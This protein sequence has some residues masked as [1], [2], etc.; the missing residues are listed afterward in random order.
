[1]SPV[2]RYISNII[3]APACAA[4]SVSGNYTIITGNVL[5]DGGSCFVA[6]TKYAQYTAGYSGGASWGGNYYTE[7]GLGA[8]SGPETIEP[9]ILGVAA[10]KNT[11]THIVIQPISV[12]A[13]E[14]VKQVWIY[15]NAELL[16]K[17]PVSN[18]TNFTTTFNM[19]PTVGVTLITARVLDLDNNLSDYSQ[20]VTYNLI[21]KV[22]PPLTAG[23][24]SINITANVT[25]PVGAIDYD[26]DV[27]ASINITVAS[28]N[29]AIPSMDTQSNYAIIGNT[30]L[31]AIEVELIPAGD[32]S[33]R[34]AVTTLNTYIEVSMDVSPN[35]TDTANVRIYYYDE[36]RQI[37]S[38]YGITIVSVMPDRIIFR[39]TH[40]SYFAASQIVPDIIPPSIK[41]IKL[42][43]ARIVTGDYVAAQPEVN[44]VA[45]DNG[46]V[47]S[48]RIIAYDSGDNP[49]A[50]ND[51]G[52]VN[53]SSA[54]TAVTLNIQLPQALTD[55]SYYIK[56]LAADLSGFVTSSQTAP[57]IVDITTGLLF[58]NVLSAPNPFNPD[59]P[60]PI[61][62]VA[63]I[64]YQLNR[65]STI[66]LYIHAINGDLIY[67]DQ[68]DSQ[69][70]YAEFVWDGRDEWGKL[71]ENGGYLA[72]LIAESGKKDVKKLIKIAV[73]R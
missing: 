32:A 51:T 21:N 34:P 3:C 16:S 26:V 41:S 72:Y 20:P 9:S 18:T 49:V 28:A 27:R 58:T 24:S 63:H 54:P 46:G 62:K 44:I 52:T 55:G 8:M 29:A 6:G 30:F 10:L 4:E 57:F 48:Y 14:L 2:I 5:F 38:D 70:G 71:V 73:L 42:N 15:E 1:M 23:S 7:L 13:N 69:I 25:L 50:G 65:A 22:N 64:G 61:R 45:T 11:T 59:D 17:A 68:Q 40:L 43:E 47:K 36:I 56:V 19:T 60:D 31:L 67:K 39:T 37:W 53:V 66:H 35:L 12:S 33:G